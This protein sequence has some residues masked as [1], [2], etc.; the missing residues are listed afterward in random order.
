MQSVLT[1]LWSCLKREMVETVKKTQSMKAEGQAQWGTLLFCLHQLYSVLAISQRA[2]KDIVTS[3]LCTR[4]M[5]TV[6][7]EQL[8]G[9]GSE[10]GAGRPLIGS[11][12]PGYSSFD[13]VVSPGKILN[14]GVLFVYVNEHWFKS[15]WAG[16]YLVRQPLWRSV[17][18]GE[19]WHVVF[20]LNSC[21]FRTMSS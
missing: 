16:W 11:S 10:G 18:M 5:C 19:C 14:Q 8:G 7:T 15:W 3:W 4:E 6:D 2:L 21:E 12:I 13:V 17:C 1:T 9:C 20:E